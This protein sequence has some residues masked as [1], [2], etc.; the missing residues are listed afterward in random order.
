[1]ASL[2]DAFT[3]R[4]AARE[5]SPGAAVEPQAVQDTGRAPQTAGFPKLQR[6]DVRQIRRD[7]LWLFHCGLAGIPQ[8][9][10]LVRMHVEQFRD[11]GGRLVSA[12]TEKSQRGR[13]AE[14]HSQPVN[15]Y[16]S[17]PL[18]PWR[19]HAAR[20]GGFFLNLLGGLLLVTTLALGFF[21][22]V[23]IPA[24]LAAGAFNFA[25]PVSQEV[26]STFG[27]TAWPDPVNQVV[28]FVTLLLAVGT[29]ITLI[30]ARRASG[31]LHMLRVVISGAGC[32][33]HDFS[34]RELRVQ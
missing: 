15:S 5:Q 30:A 9:V 7:I 16:S 10:H 32:A 28:G 34:A 21:L 33:E 17:V 3:P 1:M 29:M 19:V 23:D 20:V 8:F 4:P 14:G 2:D 13:S 12:W 31:V 6:L 24:A 18:D 11:S 25:G 27:T 26:A 22:A